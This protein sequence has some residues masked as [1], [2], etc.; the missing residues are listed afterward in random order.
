MTWLLEPFAVVFVQRALLAGLLAAV[1]CAVAGTWIVLRGM[2]FLGD[3]MSHGMLPGV[4]AAALLGFNPLLGA[5]A[6]AAVMAAGI[7]AAGRSRRL[8]QDTAIGLLFAGML[9]LGVII[10]SRSGS[11]AVD[12]TGI[13]FGDILAV[14]PRDLAVLAAALLVTCVLAAA[15]HRAF[16]AAAFDT[17]KAATLGLHPKLAHGVLMAMM[18]IAISASFQVV[19]T[20]LVFGLLIAP[21]AA[22]RLWSSTVPA[23]MLGAAAV[24]SFSVAAGLLISWHAAT[25]AGATITAVAVLVFFLACALQPLLHGVRRRSRCRRSRRPALSADTSR[26]SPSTRS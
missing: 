10:I 17:R 22:S 19:G 15:F 1:L 20:L 7:S 18:I 25:A 11:F 4:A 8:S 16:T 26:L 12:L 23:M 14:R 21:A 2:A 6:S 13:L 5:A 24:G 9:A 3:A